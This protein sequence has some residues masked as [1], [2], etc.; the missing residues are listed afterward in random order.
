MGGGAN[1]SWC[2]VRGGVH[3]GQ[4]ASWETKRQTF[5][6]FNL[7][8]EGK[9]EVHSERLRTEPSFKPKSSLLRARLLISLEII[10]VQ[11]LLCSLFKAILV[12]VNNFMTEK[13][14]TGCFLQT[15]A[16]NTKNQ[17]SQGMTEKGS[18]LSSIWKKWSRPSLRIP[19]RWISCQIM[20]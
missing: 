2:W 3:R 14:M 8:T 15:D 19:P 20:L 4:I 1:P 7:D 6:I 10:M 12:V 16:T 18:C 11:L 9:W 5:T 13:T 17:H